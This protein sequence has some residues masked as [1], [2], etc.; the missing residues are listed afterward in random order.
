[1][2]RQHELLPALRATRDD[3][4]SGDEPIF[5]NDFEG[6]DDD[7][8]ETDEDDTVAVDADA[9]GDWRAVRQRLMQSTTSVE[10]SKSSQTQNSKLLESQ[11]PAPGG[12]VPNVGVGARNRD[13]TS[14]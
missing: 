13:G 6:F 1:M 8:D 14:Y 3:G 5:Y 10:I 2:S 11:N 12:R 9:L 4:G 7:S